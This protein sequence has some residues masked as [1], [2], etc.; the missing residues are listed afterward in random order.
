MGS[1]SGRAWRP[2][3]LLKGKHCI[4]V[5]GRSHIRF[6]S[7]EFSFLSKAMFKSIYISPDPTLRSPKI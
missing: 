5:V 7:E 3:I 6:D 4:I 1:K 2:A